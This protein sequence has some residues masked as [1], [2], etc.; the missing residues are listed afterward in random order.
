MQGREQSRKELLPPKH[1]PALRK[2]KRKEKKRGKD[3][4]QVLFSPGISSHP[5][6]SYFSVWVPLRHPAR[7]AEYILEL[8]PKPPHP[9]E[10]SFSLWGLSKQDFRNETN[11]SPTP[12][13]RI[14]RG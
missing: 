4:M 11:N 7:D 13:R 9:Q 3:W 2:R 8:H 6:F 12:N 14:K 1:R 5:V 10:F